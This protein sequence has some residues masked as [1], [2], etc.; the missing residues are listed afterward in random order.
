MP[1]CPRPGGRGAAQG[2]AILRFVFRLGR[3]A[4]YCRA[5]EVDVLR[6]G[7][8]GLGFL[9]CAVASF[10]YGTWAWSGGLLGLGEALPGGV[11][12]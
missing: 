10:C 8:F 3:V 12:G 4:H 2:Q 11:H 7:G 9:G 6:G 5:A 1:R